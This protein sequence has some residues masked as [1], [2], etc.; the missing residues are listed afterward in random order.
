VADGLKRGL[1]QGFTLIAKASGGAKW[2][3]DNRRSW[4]QAGPAGVMGA[5]D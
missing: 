5:V 3:H 4:G 2:G 1:C